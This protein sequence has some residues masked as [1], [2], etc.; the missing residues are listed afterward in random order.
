MKTQLTGRHLNELNRNIDRSHERLSKQIDNRISRLETMVERKFKYLERGIDIDNTHHEKMAELR[1]DR[2][3][4][5]I[6]HIAG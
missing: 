2:L 1:A 6:G 4:S 5:Q 3:L